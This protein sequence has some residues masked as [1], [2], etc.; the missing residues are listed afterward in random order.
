VIRA[1]AVEKRYGRRRALRPLD[2]DLDRG[3]FAVVTGANGS[4]KTTLLRLVAGLAAPTGGSLDVEASRE[5]LGYLGHE[6]LLYRDLTAL[7]NLDLYGR[8]YRVPE[9]RERIGM[10][11]ERFGLWDVRRER[12]G[13]F[14]R[15]MTQRLALCRTLLHDPS[16]LVLDEPFTA[17]DAEG[18][19]LFDR[20]LAE[21]A[22]TATVLLSTHDPARV[23]PLATTRV[24]L[25]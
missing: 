23:E 1:R 10:L 12:V 22:G 18:A 16:L 4:G 13:S 24:A 3:G 19:E 21:L 14:S 17:L 11:L 6:P 2:L 25:A 7:E 9:R 5:E 8:L 20:L 15:G